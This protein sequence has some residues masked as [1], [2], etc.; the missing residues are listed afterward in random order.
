MPNSK[1]PK[2]AISHGLYSTDI[3][4]S[5]ENQQD[6]DDLLQALQD[7]YC[8][9]AITEKF[10]VFDLASLHWKKRRIETR[11][12]T[13]LQMQG[14]PD[15]VTDA[16]SDWD[17][18]A[19]D[20]RAAAK[21]QLK[22]AKHVSDMIFEYMART[23]KPGQAKADSDA[24]EFEK[25]TTLVKELSIISEGFVTPILKAAEKQK[26]DQA[27]RAYNPGIMERELKLHAEI[28]RRIEKAMKR[29]VMIKE[30]KEFYVPKAIDAKPAQ[31]ETPPANGISDSGRTEYEG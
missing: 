18:V 31:I 5:W 21:W 22:A 15:T 12:R 6:F 2:N 27:E 23:V 24:V 11:S 20:A 7:E 10:A 8:P 3:V 14:D 4:L 1:A 30:Y 29:L 16:S 9:V 28:D 17:S 26:L 19:D 13:A 25:L